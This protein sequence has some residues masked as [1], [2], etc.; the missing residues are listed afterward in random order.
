MQNRSKV[1]IHILYV[2]NTNAVITQDML[3]CITPPCK[4]NRTN[5]TVCGVDDQE[6]MNVD[7]CNYRGFRYVPQIP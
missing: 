6:F 3:K 2:Y 4:I 7:H 1:Y 5:S